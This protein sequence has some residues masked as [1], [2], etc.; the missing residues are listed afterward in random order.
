MKIIKTSCIVAALILSGCHKE[1]AH[2]L[3]GWQDIKPIIEACRS[4]PH[5]VD[6]VSNDASWDIPIDC[7]RMLQQYGKNG[8]EAEGK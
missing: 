3:I 7:Q 8:G 5:N 1:V 2:S 4:N 6:V